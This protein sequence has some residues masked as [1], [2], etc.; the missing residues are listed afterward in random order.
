MKSVHVQNYNENTVSVNRW[1][2]MTLTLS[3]FSI[4]LL[5]VF[6]LPL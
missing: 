4:T 2:F 5:L 6:S 1:R 3:L